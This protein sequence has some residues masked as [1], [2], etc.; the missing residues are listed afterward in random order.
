MHIHITKIAYQNAIS[1]QFAI[2]SLKKRRKFSYCI[3]QIKRITEQ[4]LRQTITLTGMRFFN[5]SHRLLLS[6]VGIIITYEL[7]LVQ[8]NQT[9]QVS[10]S[11]PCNLTVANVSSKDFQWNKKRKAIDCT[12]R[13]G[14]KD[15]QEYAY[16]YGWKNSCWKR[17]NVLIFS[18]YNCIHIFHFLLQCFEETIMA[19]SSCDVCVPRF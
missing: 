18:I 10:D 1:I 19:T 14:R 5:I 7:V 11:N 9:D 15:E 13:E 16:V 3:P 17:S 6:I 8:F 12:W 2:S 4:L